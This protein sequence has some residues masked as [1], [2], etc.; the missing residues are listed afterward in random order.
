MLTK[1]KKISRKEIKQD[2][3]VTFYYKA[4][5]FLD[6][7]RKNL[8]IGV[9]VIAVIV[10]VS[11]I[12]ISKRAKGNEIA[13]A[14]LL[15]VVQIYN[16]GA[17]QD[18]IDGKQTQTVKVKGLKKIV[19]ENGSSEAGQTAKIYLAN[20]YY[21]LKQYDNA[22]NAFDSYSGSIDHLKAAAYAG[23]A[24]CFEAKNDVQ[25]AVDYYLK[26]A[27]VSSVNVLNPFYL[28]NASI[29]YIE[30]GKN[31]EAKELLKSIKKDYPKSE[32]AGQVDRY[33]SQVE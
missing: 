6:E 14:D 27:K 11:L 7:Q 32:Y 21:N 24:A 17:Y 20:A 9:G 12:F 28:L 2:S 16:Q 33:L 4:I 22:L 30:L 5:Q 10:A 15:Q 31:D 23:Q 3:L 25:K 29:N 8:L 26:A 18:A 1:N 13:G 19:E